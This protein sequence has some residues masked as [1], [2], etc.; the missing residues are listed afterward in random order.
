MSNKTCRTAPL[1]I[2]ITL[3]VLPMLYVASYAAL[4]DTS[5][6]WVMGDD[7]ICYVRQYRYGGKAAEVV[8]WPLR[9]IDR[10]LRGEA[11]SHS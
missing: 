7:G 11:G 8:Y 2:A 4:V 9:Q 10:Q 5:G 1:L 6:K 3:L